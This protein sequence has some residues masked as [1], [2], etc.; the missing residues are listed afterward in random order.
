MKF[1]VFFHSPREFHID[2]LLHPTS[3]VG[4]RWAVMVPYF[5]TRGV[6]SFT[7]FPKA[8]DKLGHTFFSASGF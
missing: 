3:G 6:A 8:C 5:A 4:H 1:G 7:Y 2:L